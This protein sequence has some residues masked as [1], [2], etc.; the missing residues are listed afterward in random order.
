[1]DRICAAVQ[2]SLASFS[3]KLPLSHGR[4]T[5]NAMLIDTNETG[6]SLS[7]HL[8]AGN[9]NGRCSDRFYKSIVY[10]E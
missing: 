7:N 6:G 9:E 2:P 3:H 8:T 5:S 1:M 10:G 4:C